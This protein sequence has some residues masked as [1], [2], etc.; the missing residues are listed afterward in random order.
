MK[1]TAVLTAMLA[2]IGLLSMAEHEND[3]QCEQPYSTV[4]VL[5]KETHRHALTNWG[6][7]MYANKR[8]VSEYNHANEYYILEL[9]HKN[10]DV[11]SKEVSEKVYVFFNEPNLDVIGESCPKPINKILYIG[12]DAFEELNALSVNDVNIQFPD[13]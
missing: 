9:R 11:H 2:S 5:N 3:N 4:A 12:V 8:I 1:L 10:S 7:E 13:E 6:T